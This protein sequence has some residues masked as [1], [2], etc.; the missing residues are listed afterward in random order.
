[1]KSIILLSCLVM[2]SLSY[3]VNETLWSDWNSGSWSPP[4]SYN[5]SWTVPSNSKIRNTGSEASLMASRNLQYMWYDTSANIY[6][7]GPETY[8]NSAL[9]CERNSYYWDTD[10]W[11]LDCYPHINSAC[12]HST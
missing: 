6:E 9:K 10:A 5:S 12:T 4:S 11:G 3:A 8:L 2:L 7:C 1:M